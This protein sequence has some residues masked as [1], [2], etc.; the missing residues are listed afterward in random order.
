HG[1]LQHVAVAP[2]VT[3]VSHRCLHGV[4]GAH[5]HTTTPPGCAKHTTG[6]RCAAACSPS[7][8]NGLKCA[9]GSVSHN[10]IAAR[11]AFIII[12]HPPTPA[13]PRVVIGRNAIAR[14]QVSTGSSATAF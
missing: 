13:S 1:R 6:C 9:C 10:A 12:I 5:G 14:L 7:H 11:C 8:G 4:R 3:N 2:H